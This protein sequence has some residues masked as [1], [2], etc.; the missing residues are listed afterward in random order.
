MVFRQNCI[1]LH[2]RELSPR[3]R[4]PHYGSERLLTGFRAHSKMGQVG[5]RTQVL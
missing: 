1:H 3:H 5:T 4:H 2:Q